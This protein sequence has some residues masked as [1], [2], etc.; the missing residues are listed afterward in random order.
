MASPL[1][2]VLIGKVQF[3]IS[4]S[5]C[6]L[7]YVP[8]KYKSSAIPERLGLHSLKEPLILVIEGAHAAYL[9]ALNVDCVSFQRYNILYT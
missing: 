6:E 4:T 7:K 2:S 8:R 9:K 5:S 1:G 3:F